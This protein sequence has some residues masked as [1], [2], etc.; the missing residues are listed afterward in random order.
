[1]ENWP[2]FVK[3]L[4][5][6]MGFQDFRVD[7]DAEAERGMAFIYDHPSLVKENLPVLVES[8]NHLIQVVSRKNNQPPVFFDLNNYRQERE[9]LITELAKAAA[10]KVLV[11]GEDLSL[12]A[13]NAYERRLVHLAL[14]I[15]PEVK[16]ESLGLKRER[17]V[18]IKKIKES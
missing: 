12:P 8:I 11:T 3:T 1:M 14:A 9:N 10:K 5:E 17:H 18:I 6:S 16:T 13:M 2:N 4:I 15:H 7:L